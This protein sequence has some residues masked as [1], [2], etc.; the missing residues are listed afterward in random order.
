MFLHRN[1]NL[2]PM[3]L[4]RQVLG[5]LDLY[6]MVCV[7]QP[8]TSKTAWAYPGNGA[9][10]VAVQSVV[11]TRGSGLSLASWSLAVRA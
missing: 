1:V 2:S 9:V 7:R 10:N 5:A 8:W 11:S 4:C 6:H 3:Y